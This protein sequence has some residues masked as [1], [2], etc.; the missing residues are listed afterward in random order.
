MWRKTTLIGALALIGAL[1]SA[2]Q[3]PAGT[4]ISGAA[5][6]KLVSLR[7]VRVSPAR[8]TIRRGTT[9]TWRW[10]DAS[11]EAQ[12]NVTSL[13]RRGGR[14]FRSSP[15]QLT[16]KYSVRFTRAGTYAYECTI[17]PLSMQ[18]LVIVR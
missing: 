17:H 18:G 6:T 8:L 2:D 15:T 12:H 5:A 10:L 1:V 16:G 9:V 3:A 7:D 4:P 11:I 14:R 13:A